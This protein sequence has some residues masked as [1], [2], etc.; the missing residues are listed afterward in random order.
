MQAILTIS[1]ASSSLLMASSDSDILVQISNIC[2]L[3]IVKLNSLYHL[4]KKLAIQNTIVTPYSN[5]I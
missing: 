4:E 2:F 1:T 5:C 3:L